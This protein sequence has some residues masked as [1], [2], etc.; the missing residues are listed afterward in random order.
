MRETDT[1][2]RLKL[3]EW[4][5]DY[6]FYGGRILEWEERSTGVWILLKNVD[7]AKHEPHLSGEEIDRTAIRIDHLW[8]IQ[9]KETIKNQEKEGYCK[10]ERLKYVYLRGR[11]YQYRRLDGSIDYAI[12]SVGSLDTDHLLD[13]WKGAERQRDYELM[14]AVS[15]IVIEAWEVQKCP[16]TTRSQST[17]DMVALHKETIRRCTKCIKRRDKVRQHRA[18]KH[19]ARTR[20]GL[21]KGFG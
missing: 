16:V 6:V 18:G 3:A 13:I 10:L 21:A 12:S 19:L 15:E 2:T 20:Q 5:D 7:I 4:V 9:S 8:V 11:P 17:N 14:A 1:P